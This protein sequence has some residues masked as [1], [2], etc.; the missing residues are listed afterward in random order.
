LLE[1]FQTDNSPALLFVL[2]RNSI[3]R[4]AG[5]LTMSCSVYYLFVIY[6][7]QHNDLVMMIMRFFSRGKKKLIVS[8]QVTG[9]LFPVPPLTVLFQYEM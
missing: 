4:P 5:M 7:L 3:S 8:G 1:L 2:C 6:Y 9:M